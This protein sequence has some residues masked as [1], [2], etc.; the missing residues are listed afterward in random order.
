M[1]A[2]YIDEED[3]DQKTRMRLVVA[4]LDQCDMTKM[5]SLC[6]KIQLIGLSETDAIEQLFK[7]MIASIAAV[8]GSNLGDDVH[9][10]VESLK[11]SGK[12]LM[13]GR[14]LSFN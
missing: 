6:E 7:I 14:S 1:L 8:S 5:N 12:I 2:K 4:G 10:G 13:R 11:K 3:K 9:L